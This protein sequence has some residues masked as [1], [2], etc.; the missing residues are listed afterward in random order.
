MSLQLTGLILLF[1]FAGSRGREPPAFST[2]WTLR[3]L[4][5]LFMQLS[6]NVLATDWSHLVICFRG[7]KGAR[8]P[9]VFRCCVL[10]EA[11]SF[12][13]CRCRSLSLQL[14]DLIWLLVVAGSWGRE[15]PAFFGAMSYRS[16]GLFI[17]SDVVQ[18]LCN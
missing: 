18:C 9:S 3:G 12:Y 6:F 10:Y 8:A 14:T 5:F 11:W 4:V 1:V 7:V 17:S 15:P 2:L 13:L 16:L